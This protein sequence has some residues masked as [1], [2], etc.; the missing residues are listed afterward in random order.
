MFQRVDHRD[1][2]RPLRLVERS[3]VSIHLSLVSNSGCLVS[4]SAVVDV[5]LLEIRQILDGIVEV[6]DNHLVV[7][8][9]SSLLLRN[10]VV[11]AASEVFITYKRYALFVVAIAVGNIEVTEG[12]HKERLAKRAL[13]D[14]GKSGFMLLI[15]QL[16]HNPVGTRD[17]T[18]Q[19]LVCTFKRRLVTCVLERGE[20]VVAARTTPNDVARTTLLPID[21][22]TEETLLMNR[23]IE[24]IDSIYRLVVISKI[25]RRRRIALLLYVEEVATRTQQCR[26]ENGC[27]YIFCFHRYCFLVVLVSKFHTE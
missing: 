23:S 3:P 6:F 18:C 16:L 9:Y 7:V 5:V 2:V 24:S 8:H 12:T 25:L 1:D 27:Q 15:Q 11:V 19:T 10:R 4:T 13:L 14:S 22:A 17:N 26:R 20:G 21:F